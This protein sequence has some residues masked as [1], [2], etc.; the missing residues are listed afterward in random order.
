[1]QTTKYL[2]LVVGPKTVISIQDLMVKLQCLLERVP[3]GVSAQCNFALSKSARECMSNIYPVR[4]VKGCFSHF[5]LYHLENN[6]ITRDLPL[7]KRN[8]WLTH[9][10]EQYNAW[11]LKQIHEEH[12]NDGAQIV[13]ESQNE[14]ALQAF[15]K[16]GYG[17]FDEIFNAPIYLLNRYTYTRYYYIDT[18]QV[19]FYVDE[20]ALTP[21][22]FYVT[23]TLSIASGHT[24]K[25]GTEYDNLQVIQP[26]QS[27]L[28]EGLM[29][30]APQKYQQ[31]IERKVIGTYAFSEYGVNRFNEMTMSNEDREA[32]KIYLQQVVDF[33]KDY[34]KS[35][36]INTSHWTIRDKIYHYERVMQALQIDSDEEDA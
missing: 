6:E 35:A 33:C 12:Q 16:L 3:T 4:K 14:E 36:W 17:T 23:G 7:M 2:E 24:I 27:A 21:E 34:D 15:N 32:Y 13:E 10:N 26:V 22:E 28:L 19:K 29:V 1:M 18:T 8:I 30:D 20:T 31:L 11:T 5:D 9:N 25:A